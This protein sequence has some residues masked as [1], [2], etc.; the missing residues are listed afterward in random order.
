MRRLFNKLKNTVLVLLSVAII[1]FTVYSWITDEKMEPIADVNGANDH[2]L[3][4]ITDEQIANDELGATGLR[5]STT[6]RKGLLGLS[7][8]VETKIKAKDF[9]GIYHLNSWNFIGTGFLSLE[10]HDAKFESGNYRMCLVHEGQIVKDAQL[11][12]GS[13]RFDIDNLEAGYYELLIAGESANF[14]FQ[15]YHLDEYESY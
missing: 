5:Y 11:S 6:T 2:S 15:S 3:A 4:V 1:G 10:F 9:S 8:T 13:F 12:D 7:V 14:Q